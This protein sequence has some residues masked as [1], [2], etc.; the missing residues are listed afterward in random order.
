MITGNA[1]TSAVAERKAD[2]QNRERNSRQEQ[3]DQVTY[4]VPSRPIRMVVAH[5]SNFVAAISSNGEKSSTG[6]AAEAQSV[7]AAHELKGR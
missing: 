3:H 5:F 2:D 4:W 7:V 6:R 1:R